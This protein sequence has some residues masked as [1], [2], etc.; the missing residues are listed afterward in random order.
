MSDHRSDD[1]LVADLL[2][3]RVGG[4]EPG[5][6]ATLTVQAR[7]ET[8]SLRGLA[9]PGLFAALTFFGMYTHNELRASIRSFLHAASTQ[10]SL[11]HSKLDASWSVCASYINQPVGHLL[12]A[13]CSLLLALCSL[14][15]ALCSGGTCV[16]PALVLATA[17]TPS[18]HR[19]ARKYSLNSEQ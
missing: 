15:R 6:C 4:A 17:C 13:L 14:L 5:R 10:W 3:L 9:E 2:I 19:T 8:T 16:W 11:M 18:C 1:L 7:L 12:L